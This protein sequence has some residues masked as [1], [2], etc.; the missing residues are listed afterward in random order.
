MG[1][2][3]ALLADVILDPLSGS[4]GPGLRSLPREV[5]ETSLP[6]VLGVGPFLLT[7][8]VRINLCSDI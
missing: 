5:G 1:A 7:P 2:V 6:H 8:R 3:S 4:P